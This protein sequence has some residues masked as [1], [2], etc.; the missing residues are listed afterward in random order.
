MLDGHLQ[1]YT[2]L[3]PV[4]TVD[5]IIARC[6]YMILTDQNLGAEYVFPAKIYDAVLRFEVTGNS[7]E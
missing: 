1:S 7:I 3:V 2:E 5:G 4:E 6:S